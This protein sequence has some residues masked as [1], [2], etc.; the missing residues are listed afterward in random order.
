M[1]NKICLCCGSK[2]FELFKCNGHIILSDRTPINQNLENFICKKCS[3]IKNN[4]YKKK[5]IKK[6]YKNDYNFLISKN[7]TTKHYISNKKDIGTYD[8]IYNFIKK[9]IKIQ[10]ITKILEIG[11]GTGLLINNFIKNNKN[12]K[13]CTIYEPSKNAFKI[14]KE[15][16]LK[17]KNIKIYNEFYTG[18]LKKNDFDLI[19]CTGV[20]EHVPNPIKLIKNI[21]KHLNPDGKIVIG[22]PNFKK[23]YDDIIVADHLNKFSEKSLNYLYNKTKTNLIYRDPNK[24]SIWILDIINNNF[25]KKNNIKFKFN[26]INKKE[27]LQ[28]FLKTKKQFNNFINLK[29]KNLAFYGSGNIGLFFLINS[30]YVKK[31]KYLILDD[32]SLPKKF[33]NMKVISLSKLKKYKIKNVF[34][35]ANQ[36]HHKIMLNK[37]RKLLFKKNNIYY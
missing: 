35:S 12:I 29:D 32:N 26:I 13:N 36:M 28:Y 14:L 8:Y 3:F 5:K 25:K 27:I 17:N 21:K 19:L 1:N 7:S 22:V 11:S 33:L 31:V 37:L 9:N 4:F 23:K 18:K 6:I 10:K 34:L 30:K 24:N 15:K 16:F 2:M 20:L